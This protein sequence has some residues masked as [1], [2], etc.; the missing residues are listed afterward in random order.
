M[1]GSESSQ[2]EKVSQAIAEGYDVQQMELME[3]M[4]ILVNEN[5]ESLGSASKK[6][7]HEVNSIEQG[8]LHRAFSVFL[9][10]ATG[11]QLLLQ[12]RAKEKITFPDCWTNACCSHPLFVEDEREEHEQ[13]GIKRAAIRKLHH[14][15]GIEG[16]STDDLNY[17][18][19]V[20]YK[21]VS[22]SVWGEHEIDYIL[23]LKK[24]VVLH[25]NRNEVKDY[26]YVTRDELRDLMMSSIKWTPWF[27]LIAETY[28]FE[29]WKLLELNIPLVDFRTTIHRIN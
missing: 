26:R 10:D 11:E 5:D 19:R 7:C 20:H 23:F 18:T 14:E 27:R 24:D 15:L 29:W 17:I 4:C 8:M 6:V 2:T 16:I 1:F 12:Q 28:L 3:E 9:F 21:A 22:D 25:I 13:M